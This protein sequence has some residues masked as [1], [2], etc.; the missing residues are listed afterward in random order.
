MGKATQT[1]KQFFHHQASGGIILLVAAAIA[2]FISNSQF[3]AIYHN[4]LSFPAPI[5]LPLL[6]FYKEMN[7]KL[8]I[9]D[10]LM[11]VF[12]LLV[13]LELKREIMIGE[14]SSKSKMILPFLAAVSG[15]ILPA[16]IYFLINRNEAQN[17][18]GIA[19]PTAT[20]IA[21]AVAILS[22]FGNKISTS[23]K[24]FLVALAIIDDLIAILIIA[25]FYASAI[26][27]E[28]LLY[29]FFAI[30]LLFFLNKKRIYTLSPYLLIAPFLW[31]FVLKSGLHPTIAGVVLAFLIPSGNEEKL[32]SKAKT[33]SQ[34]LENFLHL[35]VTYIILPI[36]AFANS[37]LVLQDFSWG[38]FNSKIVLGII[39]GLFFGKQIGVFLSVYL[40]DK[41]K[42]C[43]FFKNTGWLEFYG[44]SIITGIG[45]TMSLFIG[46]LAFFEKQELIDQVKIGVISASVLSAL[47]GALILWIATNVKS[48]L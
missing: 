32:D 34:N 35:P 29:A 47:F 3:S 16:S 39:F 20:D 4:F 48:R 37:G 19:I 11:S 43:P 2:L 23:L 12:F 15:V 6:A 38:V 8:W 9:D 5:N 22:L 24:I 13:G 17:L 40:L 45:F 30:F 21:F 14:L 27:F 1:I 42:L 41:F 18:P 46:N 10:C 26:N 33:P 25:I 7:I 28:Y 44:V 31:L 36:F